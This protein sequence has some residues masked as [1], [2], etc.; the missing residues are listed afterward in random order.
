VIRVR[1]LIVV[2]VCSALVACGSAKP[3]TND[4]KQSDAQNTSAASGASTA[5]TGPT[6]QAV[7]DQFVA[8]GLPVPN[9][10]NNS[11]NCKT[12]GCT[13]LITT[14]AISI[15]VWPNESSAQHQVDVAAGDA[16]R[17]GTIVLSYTAARTP[18]TDR[19]LYEAALKNIAG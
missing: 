8:S 16:Y 17:Y 7:V 5:T 1:Y 3:A 18:S 4:E 12:L 14:D 9:P 11:K 13:E 2:G 10:R 6:A 15:Y 19:P